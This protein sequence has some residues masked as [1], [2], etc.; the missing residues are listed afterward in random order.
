VAAGL[1]G[2]VLA[3]GAG[4]RT[5]PPGRVQHQINQGVAAAGLHAAL[6]PRNSAVAGILIQDREHTHSVLGG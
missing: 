2:G 4:A 5:P 6:I 1:L 3:N